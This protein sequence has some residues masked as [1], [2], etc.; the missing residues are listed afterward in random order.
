MNYRILNAPVKLVLSDTGKYYEPDILIVFDI[1]KIKEDGCYGVPDI[2]IEIVSKSTKK[3]DYELKKDIYL[4]NGVKE[5]LIIDPLKKIT[6]IYYESKKTEKLFS[7]DIEIR[8][9]SGLTINIE[10]ML[11]SYTLKF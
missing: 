5:Y 10:K 6:T 11:R 3:N 9:L 1:S 4:S 7:E 8:N 2:I